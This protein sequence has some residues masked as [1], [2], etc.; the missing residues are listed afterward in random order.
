MLSICLE[1][2]EK[3]A[4][5]IYV[6]TSLEKDVISCDFFFEINGNIVRKHELNNAVNDGSFHY[7]TSPERQK[8]A[9]HILAQKI[10]DFY[11]L[12]T[13]N[14]QEMPTEIK[15]TY[16]VKTNKFAANYK[17]EPV[18]SSNVFEEWID[19][20]KNEA[21]AT[22]YSKD[23]VG[24][25][26]VSTKYMIQCISIIRKYNKKTIPETQK[27]INSKSFVFACECTDTNGLQKVK[28]CHDELLRI[29]T[30]VNIY[31]GGELVQKDFFANC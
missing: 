23:K 14:H 13:E 17:Y 16:N 2:A 26:I 29:G 8:A 15:L 25:V 24:L 12:C 21:N 6:Y 5:K 4:D 9:I 20:I 11:T 27:M 10:I 7:N 28:Q 18:T 30:K 22:R 3:R 31:A 1:Y 19:E